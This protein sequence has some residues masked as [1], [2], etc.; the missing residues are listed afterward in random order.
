MLANMGR[1]NLPVLW[2]GVGQDVLDEVVA[3]L[4][5]SDIDERDPR[6][7]DPALTDSV[8]IAAE[9]LGATNLETLL[10][11]LGC[12]LVHAILGGIADDMINGSA[13]VSGGPMLADMLDTPVSELSVGDNID[14]CKDLLDAGTLKNA[15]SDT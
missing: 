7:I 12:K 2:V 5:T 9:E 14:V 3:V 4:V 1:D 8:Q 6:T 15:V 10:H 13:S 11:H